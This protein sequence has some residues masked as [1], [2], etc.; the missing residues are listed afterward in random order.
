MD[1]SAATDI[2]ADS[3]RPCHQVLVASAIGPDD[4]DSTR[5]LPKPLSLLRTLLRLI[6][7]SNWRGLPQVMVRTRV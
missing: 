6:R 1:P 2:P 5:F 3:Q 4:P 7:N